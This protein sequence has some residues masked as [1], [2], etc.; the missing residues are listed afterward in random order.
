MINTKAG[1]CGC[2]VDFLWLLFVIG[3]DQLTKIIV[4]VMLRIL[5]F[6]SLVF[7]SCGCLWLGLINIKAGSF[8]LAR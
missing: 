1:F 3:S 7:L 8:I 4:V 2:A 6:V 5:F